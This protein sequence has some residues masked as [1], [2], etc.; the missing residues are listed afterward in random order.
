MR[1]DRTLL[2]GRDSKTRAVL[3]AGAVMLL[4]ACS[5]SAESPADSEPVGGTP[6]AAGSGAESAPVAPAQAAVPAAPPTGDAQGA[7]PTVRDIGSLVGLWR[8][9]RV[10]GAGN[11][12]GAALGKDDPRILGAVMEVARDQI[13]W[14]YRPDRSLPGNDIC[15]GP[16][17]S[18][19]EVPD[20][21]PQL[22]RRVNA[23]V[24]HLVPGSTTGILHGIDCGDD[25]RW[26][27]GAVGTAYL[28][29]L[30]PDL[31][32]MTWF[33]DSVLLLQ[34]FGGK[35]GAAPGKAAQPLHA[36]DYTP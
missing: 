29:P 21:D 9:T 7:A 1:L 8:V 26:G 36:S 11:G 6:S 28:S 16:R 3:L 34:R 2:R 15:S 20:A 17:V 18:P 4:A 25:G 23:A 30:G 22:T 19:V 10:D 32:A 35:R 33:D 31:M 24:L 5:R 27:P 13:N 12:R 14:S